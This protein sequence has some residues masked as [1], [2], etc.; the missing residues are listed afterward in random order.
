[1][2]KTGYVYL[3]TNKRKTVLYTGVTS[4]LK[5]RIRT[6]Q[7]NPSGFAKRYNCH[8]CVY[9]ETIHGM[10]KAIQREKE[11]KGWIRAKKNALIETENPE[12]RFLNAEIFGEE[13]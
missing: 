1:M 10:L 5:A 11:I 12:W 8:Y 13:V 6:H 9:Y 7:D 2:A 4:D 3:I